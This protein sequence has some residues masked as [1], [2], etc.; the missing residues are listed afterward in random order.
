MSEERG[1]GLTFDD[2]ASDA[3]NARNVSQVTL[4]EERVTDFSVIL[5]TTVAVPDIAAGIL[6]APICAIVG[7]VWGVLNTMAISS[8]VRWKQSIPQKTDPVETDAIH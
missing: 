2:S 7:G 3:R 5:N 6:R 8:P 1:S 4:Q